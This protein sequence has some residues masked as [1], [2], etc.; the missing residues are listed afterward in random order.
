[1]NLYIINTKPIFIDEN[2]KPFIYQYRRKLNKY[3][4]RYGKIMICK[5]CNKTFFTYHDSEFCSV[6]CSKKYVNIKKIIII[7]NE[8]I[9]ITDNEKYFKFII[10]NKNKKQKIYGKI[11]ECDYCGNKIFR[12]N[13]DINTH[14]FCCFE[15]YNK[16]NVGENNCSWKGGITSLYM[17]YRNSNGC[18]NWRKMCMT[19]DNFTC[20]LCGKYG[21]DLNVHHIKSVKD[22]FE[23]NVV[24]DMIDINNCEELWDI[25]NG[26]TV[27]R[28]CHHKLHRGELEW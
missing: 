19:R 27:C 1:M 25:N 5:Y 28:D 9:F 13:A 4:K 20:Q 21:G 7:N 14:N 12:T 2:N 24:Q 15:C 8:K 26:I 22:I 16:F 10:N 6:P 3:I 11:L 18:Q 17:K 23:E